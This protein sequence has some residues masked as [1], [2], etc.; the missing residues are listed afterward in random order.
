L[1][2]D[3]DEGEGDGNEDDDDDD[4]FLGDGLVAI[5]LLLLLSSPSSSPPIVNVAIKLIGSAVVV[6]CY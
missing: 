3:A 2:G 4:N 5:N 6:C 1:T